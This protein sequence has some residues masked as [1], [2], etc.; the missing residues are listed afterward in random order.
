MSPKMTSRACDH[1]STVFEYPAKRKNRRY[2]SR[3]CFARHNGTPERMEKVRQGQ[4]DPNWRKRFKPRSCTHCGETYTPTAQHQRW[5]PACAPN[6]AARARLRRYGV[7][8]RAWTELVDRFNG[9]CWLCVERPATALDHDHD[10]DNGRVRGV[11]CITCN[12]NLE[13]G[14]VAISRERLTSYLSFEMIGG[15]SSYAE[16]QLRAS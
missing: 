13:R 3:P 12:A 5:C 2:C 11:L 4:T 9:L 1:C 16:E 15:D 14:Q 8:V 6:K 7:S 10:H